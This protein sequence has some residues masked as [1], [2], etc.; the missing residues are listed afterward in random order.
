M[1]NVLSAALSG[2]LSTITNIK[3]PA[4]IVETKPNNKKKVMAASI[5]GSVIGIAAAVG[6]VYALAKKGNPALTFKN[7]TYEEKDVLMVGAGSVLGGL[8]GGLIA[9]KNKDNIKPKLRESSTQFFGNMVCPISLL[10]LGNK[11]IDKFN[12]QLPKLNEINSLSKFVNPILSVLP[13][14]AMTIGALM[15]GMKIGNIIMNAVNN[16]IFN[17]KIED[18]VEAAD[19]L[20]HADD[21]CLT[22]NMLLKDAPSISTITSKILPATFIIAG[23]KSGM[24]QKEN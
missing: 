5:A 23:S 10:A 20:V 16:K 22:A 6:G 12:V 1:S 8:T 17:E 19:Y 14:V 4:A 11:L 21:L 24:Q 15:G 18:K 3:K 2:N 7:L 9:D 13:K